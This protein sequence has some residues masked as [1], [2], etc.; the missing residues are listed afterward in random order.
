MADTNKILV[1]SAAIGDF[2]VNRN[3]W[4]T[5]ENEEHVFLNGTI[6]LTCLRSEHFVLQIH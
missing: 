2:H 1:L 6:Y 3:V 4:N 5:Y